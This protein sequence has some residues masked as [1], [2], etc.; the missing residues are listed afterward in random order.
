M[1]RPPPTAGLAIGAIAESFKTSNSYAYANVGQTI[2][3]LSE[4][5]NGFDFGETWAEQ[6]GEN[7]TLAYFNTYKSQ[8]QSQPLAKFEYGPGH[9]LQ[10]GR[11][12][13]PPP[14]RY[15]MWSGC[16]APTAP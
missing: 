10:R 5:V 12:R 11:S 8:G 2:I 7:P 6:T 1:N 3:N 14:A 4:C 13:P 15:A 9:P 16:S